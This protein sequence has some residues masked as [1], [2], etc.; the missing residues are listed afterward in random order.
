M[1]MIDSFKQAIK[2]VGEVKKVWLTSFIIDIEFIETYLLP[3][4]VSAPNSKPRTHMDFEQLQQRYVESGIDIRILCD[5][6][7]LEGEAGSRLKRTSI[8]V[9]GVLPSYTDTEGK[10]FTKD[11][12]FHPKVIYIQ[13]KEGAVLGA[14]SANLT[15]SGWGRN[16]EVFKFV[17]VNSKKLSPSIFEFFKNTFE[18][19]GVNDYDWKPLPNLGNSETEDVEFLHSFSGANFIRR[20]ITADSRELTVWSPYFSKSISSF[21]D[22]IESITNN[23]ELTYRIVPDLVNGKT[24]RSASD[25][26]LNQHLQSQKIIFHKRPDAI[27]ADEFAMVHAKIWATEKDIAIGSWNF[28]QPGS[29]LLSGNSSSSSNDGG[30]SINVEAGLI[31]SAAE[32]PCFY[33]KAIDEPQFSENSELERKKLEVPAL[34]PFNVQITLDWWRLEYQVNLRRRHCAN[35]EL[36]Q[37]TLRLPG[38]KSPVPIEPIETGQTVKVDDEQALNNSRRFQVY[39]NGEI[40]SSCFIVEINNEYRR[41]QKFE[42]LTSLIDAAALDI[43]ITNSEKLTYR[44]T[45]DSDEST[46]AW[47]DKAVELTSEIPRASYFKLFLAC[48]NLAKRLTQVGQ[49]IT[50][51]VKSERR[52]L[53]ELDQMLLSIPGCLLEWVEK[54]NEQQDDSVYSWFL[55]E[56]IKQLV[57]LAKELRKPLA[58]DEFDWSRFEVQQKSTPKLTDKVIS[59]VRAEG[60]YT[61]A[62][63][64]DDR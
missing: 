39:K 11:S 30:N 64:K 31:F 16:R 36:K 10:R 48:H 9:H 17:S 24:I 58:H 41:S 44:L 49:K 21:I 33:G 62:D 26:T 18:S 47:E 23:R 27:E 15:I 37:Y 43:D 14:G 5:K 61:G 32:A 1:Q 53:K 6:R 28:T 57:K 42:D 60:R 50:K 52:Q 19:A 59:W 55:V 13:G 56:E 34:P 3:I 20:M 40:E 7:F 45:I 8:P 63:G 46:S 25:E 2:Q 12:L 38:V 22:K 54:A 29:N 35:D 51:S 4:I